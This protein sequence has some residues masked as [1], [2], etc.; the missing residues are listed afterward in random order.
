APLPSPPAARAPQKASRRSAGWLLIPLLCGLFGVGMV[1]AEIATELGRGAAAE[2]TTQSWEYCTDRLD[3]YRGV[4]GGILDGQF[5]QWPTAFALTPANAAFM[6][7][8]LSD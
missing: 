7:A 1:R 2:A 8:C 4:E 5:A 3:S 6:V